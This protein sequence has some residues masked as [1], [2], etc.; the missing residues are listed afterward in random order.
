MPLMN[1]LYSGD[2]ASATDLT[3][4]TG[5]MAIQPIV[6]GGN[7]AGAFVPASAAACV[8]WRIPRHYRGGHPRTYI[9]PLGTQAIETPTSLAPAYLLLLQNAANA[10][11]AAINGLTAD[12]KLQILCSVHRQDQKQTLIPPQK[13]LITSA[14]CDARIDSQRRR[15]GKDR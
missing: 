13:S 4:I 11:L 10:F 2:S 7:H 6:G 8:T 12:G 14:F 15:L 5:V 3:S 9:G 1:A